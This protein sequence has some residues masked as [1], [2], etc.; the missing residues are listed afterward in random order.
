M[1]KKYVHN[2]ISLSTP[3]GEVTDGVLN[4]GQHVLS[5]GLMYMEFVDAIRESYPVLAGFFYQF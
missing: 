1:V 5:L 2:F 3:R 4:Y